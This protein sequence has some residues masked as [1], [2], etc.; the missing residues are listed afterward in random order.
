MPAQ[1]IGP[2]GENRQRYPRTFSCLGRLFASIDYL[3]VRDVESQQ[4]F[5]ELTEKRPN[6]TADAAFVGEAGKVDISE[7]HS[8]LRLA[9]VL[10]SSVTGS[11]EICR[12]FLKIAEEVENLKIFPVIFQSGDELVWQN[13]GWQG[14][15]AKV[16]AGD[17]I[18]SDVDLVVSMRLHGCII[19]TSRAIPWLGIAYDPKVSAFASACNW[20]FCFE[21]E[22]IDRQLLE[23]QL[24]L[25]ASRKVEF[26]GKLARKANEMTRR[27]QQDFAEVVEILQS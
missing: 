15:L 1:G 27:A 8:E 5:F 12:H 17:P 4:A 7:A 10:R 22:K 6:V 20:K 16:K 13:C 9:V 26:A 3:T 25:L 11:E 18:F 21:P 19:A 14:E 2:W 23:Q 24:N